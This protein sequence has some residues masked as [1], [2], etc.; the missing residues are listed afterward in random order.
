M[1]TFEVFTHVVYW[2]LKANE[3]SRSKHGFNRLVVIKLLNLDG[4]KTGSPCRT[5]ELKFTRVS[6]FE[7]RVYFCRHSG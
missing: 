6:L 7:C 3:H 5:L 2:N 4:N 1:L